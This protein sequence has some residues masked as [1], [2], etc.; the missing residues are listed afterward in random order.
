MSIVALQQSYSGN[1]HNWPEVE[2]RNGWGC[3]LLY[4]LVLL[5]PRQG[6]VLQRKAKETPMQRA[7]CFHMQELFSL[8][9]IRAPERKRSNF[10]S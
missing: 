5:I 2:A 10:A 6:C 9:L 3:K 8:S 7:S 4:M 1:Q